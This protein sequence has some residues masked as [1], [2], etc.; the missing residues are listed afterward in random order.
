MTQRPMQSLLVTAETINRL[1]ICVVMILTAATGYY[2]YLGASAIELSSDWM[3][4]TG[5]ALLAL[6]V[7][8]GL[9]LFWRALLSQVPRLSCRARWLSV[10]IVVT[11]VVFAVGVST[12]FNLSGMIGPEAV[13]HHMEVTLE[14]FSDALAAARNQAQQGLEG[15]TA[16]RLNLAK[17]QQMAEAERREGRNTGGAAGD[18][19]ITGMLEQVTT[20]MA[21]AAHD[22]DA[23]VAQA[24]KLTADAGKSLDTMRAV[25]AD[26]ALPLQMKT[27]RFTSEAEALR[28]KLLE[29]S[30]LEI[31]TTVRQA[32]AAARETVKPALS[33]N[34]T[35]AE[36]QQR[37]IQE[38]SQQLGQLESL[39]LVAAQ[40]PP[41][42]ML[43]KP[44]QSITVYTAVLL[45]WM[46][47]IPAAL[48]C[49]FI[50]ILPLPMLLLKILVH[51]V[52][53]D[54]GGPDAANRYTVAEVLE[55]RELMERLGLMDSAHQSLWGEVIP[56]AAS[57]AR[58]YRMPVL[59]A[60]PR[61][62]S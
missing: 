43:G 13:R 60:F 58:R 38:L 19:A 32:I 5:C 9:Y 6:S 10:P 55:V 3:T 59:R 37:T 15:A 53:D 36:R 25:V 33:S 31:V 46:S 21:A 42:A 41:P 20:V 62:A 23:K 56:P 51:A 30:R 35:I 29:L 1:E 24:E 39:N 61:D 40:A 28:L 50:D 11:V 52:L 47:F 44:F 45:H 8:A 7:T 17:F 16:I 34:R 57:D 18:G 48:A 49:L 27:A 22:A 26:P 4:K 54:T 12:F 14:W 2:T